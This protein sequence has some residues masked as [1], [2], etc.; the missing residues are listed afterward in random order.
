MNKKTLYIVL[1]AGLCIAGYVFIIY[2]FAD[3]P[4][5]AVPDESVR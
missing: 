5:L 3:P 4:G 2:K 1:I